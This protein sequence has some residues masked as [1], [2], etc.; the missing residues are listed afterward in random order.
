MRIA[1]NVY[2]SENH[3]LEMIFTRQ[4]EKADENPEYSPRTQKENYT[5]GMHS[6]SDIYICLTSSSILSVK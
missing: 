6:Q 2:Y 3:A 1:R 4:K 5:L